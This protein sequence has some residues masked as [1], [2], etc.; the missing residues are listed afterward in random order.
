MGWKVDIEA[1]KAVVSQN[2]AYR[3]KLLVNVD[4]INAILAMYEDFVG[5]ESFKKH[6]LEGVRLRQIERECANRMDADDSVRTKLSGQRAEILFLIQSREELVIS[7]QVAEK[8]ISDLND[9][10]AKQVKKLERAT[11]VRPG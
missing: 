11:N 1:T 10:I 4:R 6:Y 2:M 3:D 7:K 8:S 9:K 5:W